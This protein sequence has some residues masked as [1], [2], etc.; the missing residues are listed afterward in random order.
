MGQQQ[1]LPKDV[2][3]AHKRF[4]PPP[5]GLGFPENYSPPCFINNKNNDVETSNIASNHA[6]LNQHHQQQ[7]QQQLTSLLHNVPPMLQ[8]HSQPQ[9]SNQNNTESTT[10][11]RITNTAFATTTSISDDETYD[12]LNQVGG[13]MAISVLDF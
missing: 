5:P 1:Q 4:I 8:P 10:T 11:T 6:Y 9:C 12:L 2:S 7:Q 13:Q 3:S